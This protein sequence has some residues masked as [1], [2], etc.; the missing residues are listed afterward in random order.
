MECADLLR[1]IGERVRAV[2]KAKRLSQE[3]LAELSGLHPV[4]ISRVEGGKV[5]ASLCSYAAIADAL[6]MPLTELVDVS[7]GRDTRSTELLVLFQAA[8]SLDKDRQ[9]IFIETVKGVLNGL[10]GG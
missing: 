4:F 8:K 10:G 6:G 1:I 9:S 5:R 3:T 2:R 7:E